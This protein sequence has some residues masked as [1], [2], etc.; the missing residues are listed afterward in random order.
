MFN[1]CKHSLSVIFFEL[2][3][4]STLCAFHAYEYI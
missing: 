4:L 3:L 1:S 2:H